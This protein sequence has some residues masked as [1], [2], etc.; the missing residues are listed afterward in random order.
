[1]KAAAIVGA[2]WGD[3][4][5]AKIIDYLSMRADI[6][7]RYQGGANAGHTVVAGGRKFVFHL[8]PSGVLYPDKICVIGNGVVVDP[9]ALLEELDSIRSLGIETDGRVLVSA[10][11]HLILPIHKALDQAFEQSM[12][13]EAIGTTRRGIGPAYADKVSRHGIQVGDLL[14]PERFEAR[15]ETL[16]ARGNRVL[17]ELFGAPAIGVEEVLEPYLA[18]GRRLAPEVRDI[19]LVLDRALAAGRRLLLEGAQ[20]TMLDVDHGTYPFVTSSNPTAGGACLGTGIGPSRIGRVVGI[21]KAYTTRVGNGPFPTELEG[22]QGD[23]L[24]EWG[25]EFGAT[26]GR[27]RRCGWFDAVA[28]RYAARINGLDELAVTKLDVLDSLDTIGICVGYRI[29]G[30]EIEDVPLRCEDWA[31][32]EPVYEWVRGW[33]EQT[34]EIRTATELPARAR[35]FLDRIGALTG[36]SVG[37]VSVGADREQTIEMPSHRVFD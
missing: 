32:V 6:V 29:E 24:R 17:H 1:M 18:A 37:L 13:G 36:V 12:G 19:S 20:G 25:N 31:R 11:A 14:Q 26:T 33:R 4:G 2:Q 22:E 21:A 3:E 9:I 27:P 34:S 15:L 16:L 30:R 28:V 10:K 8:V 5:K 23:R 35:S 7:A